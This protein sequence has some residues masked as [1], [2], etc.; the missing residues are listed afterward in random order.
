MSVRNSA[1]GALLSAVSAV[2]LLA[3]CSNGTAGGDQS[4]PSSVVPTVNATA[5]A[6][7]TTV[8]ATG[9]AA[10]ETTAPSPI[11]SDTG[12][13]RW[14]PCSLPD[15]A[16]SAA[17]LSTASKQ[18]LDAQSCRWKSAGQTSE[19]TVVSNT[20]TAAELKQSGKYVQFGDATL[21]GRA[22]LQYRAA[23]DNHKTGCYL[24]TF[25]SSGAI[26][27]VVKTLKVQTD[28]FDSCADVRQF[29]AALAG[30]L[31]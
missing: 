17:G 5:A 10:P 16:I 23:Q 15:S 1:I 21:G 6:P 26:V 29:G 20:D 31:P 18:Q 8:E 3:G 14:N 2:L 11:P 30:Y 12:S 19:L 25:T 28:D 7:A 13:A 4:S 22:A 24:T 27:F 9:K